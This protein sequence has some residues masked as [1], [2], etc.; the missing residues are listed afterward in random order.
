VK[1]SFL[2][3]L[4]IR[5]SSRLGIRMYHWQLMRDK[6]HYCSREEQFDPRESEGNQQ[7]PKREL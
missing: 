1:N 6:E 2:R 4:L 5:I 3:F 7:R